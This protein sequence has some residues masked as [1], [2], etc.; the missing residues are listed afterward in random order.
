M[1]EFR[2]ITYQSPSGPRAGLC[3][4]DGFVDAATATGMPADASV[5]AILDD[6]PAAEERLARAAA[7]QTPDAAA[8]PIAGATLLSPVH[9]PV[10]IYCAGGNYTDHVA[11]M[12]QKS[13]LPPEPDPHEVGL[14]SWH[15][16]KPSRSAVGDRAV[17]SVASSSLDWEAELAVVIG[18]PARDVSVGDALGCVA[19]YMIANDLSARDLFIRPHISGASPF[20]WDWVGQKCFD[21]SCPLGPW[22][23]PASQVPDPQSLGIRLWVNDRL[24]QDSSTSR[25]IFTVAEQISHLSSRLTL[26]PGDVILTGTPMGVGAETGEFLSAGDVMRVEIEGLGRLTTEV[27]STSGAGP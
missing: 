2:L 17:V 7:K 19:G 5:L 4:G 6:W 21:G 16:I 9:F 26:H 11:R 27:G 13:G 23:A 1:S 3:V 18:R 25:M 15:F 10:T 14:K 12:A 8:Q 22:M 20:R 24:R